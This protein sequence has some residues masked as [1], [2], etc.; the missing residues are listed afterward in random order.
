M[1]CL[2]NQNLL[3]K[4]FKLYAPAKINI[5][6]LIKKLL[7][8]GYH[9]IE[10]IMVPIKLFDILKIEITKSGIVF[11]TD[12]G[13]IPK[14]ENNLVLKAAKYFFRLVPVNAGVK[15]I[16]KK[17][18]PIGAGL[19]G[20]SSD[21][22]CTLLGLNKMFG[23]PLDFNTL[24]TIADNL[25][26]DVIFF[27]YRKPALVR[28]TGDVVRSIN[29]PKLDIVLYVPNYQIFTKQAY[30]DYDRKLLP[31]QNLNNL[32]TESDFS[33]KLIYKKLKKKDFL[34]LGSLIVN[35][36]EPIVFMKHPDLLA[37]KLKLLKDGAY[38]VGLSGTGSC[39]YGIVD[40]KMK[41]RLKREFGNRL[42][43]TETI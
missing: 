5:G 24:K 20:G 26:K 19:G 36:F 29:M 16:L 38:Y 21:A 6:L 40:N 28:G 7:P 12:C 35:S 17:K 39:L 27:L 22:A 8:T 10:T 3:R 13:H 11:D 2:N 34:N 43:F 25:G 18:I 41:F 15:I 32:L 23:Y 30:R 33:Y 37:T 4:T 1:V 31:I 42:I 9:E 14:D